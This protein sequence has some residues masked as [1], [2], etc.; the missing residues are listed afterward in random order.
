M[1]WIDRRAR[2]TKPKVQMC[3]RLADAA[4]RPPRPPTARLSQTLVQIQT[5]RDVTVFVHAVLTI[6]LQPTADAGIQNRL[7][8]VDS[9]SAGMVFVTSAAGIFA[10]RGQ[11][12]PVPL[13]CRFGDA[14]ENRRLRSTA[15][16]P[17]LHVFRIEFTN[18]L[19]M[20]RAN[21]RPRPSRRWARVRPSPTRRRIGRP[22]TLDCLT[23]TLGAWCRVPVPTPAHSAFRRVG[24]TLWKPV[25][26]AARQPSRRSLTARCGLRLDRGSLRWRRFAGDR[27]R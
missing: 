25:F 23:S 11:I 22:R 19:G 5:P 4:V 18:R 26:S 13:D 2:I 10:S 21:R 24:R 7:Q 1:A 20:L 17:A 8:L 6:Q 27:L 16:S 12:P 3:K 15:R 9:T 14:A